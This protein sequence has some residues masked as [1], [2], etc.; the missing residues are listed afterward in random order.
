MKNAAAGVH[1]RNTEGPPWRR[2]RKHENLPYRQRH[3]LPGDMGEGKSMRNI[4]L[5]LV[6]VIAAVGAFVIAASAVDSGW[7]L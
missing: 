2:Q 7:L 3:V 1:H 6:I 4:L 5:G